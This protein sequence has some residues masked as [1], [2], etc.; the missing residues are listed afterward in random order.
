[1]EQTQSLRMQQ[2]Q[3]QI[4]RLEQASL[5]DM[6]EDEFS[7]LIHNT[8]HSPLFQRIYQQQKIIRHQRFGHTDISTR[9][10]PLNEEMVA[11]NDSLEVESLLVNREHIVSKIH[12]IGPE[13]FKQYFLFPESGLTLEEIATACHLDITQVREINNLIDEF[14]IRSEFYHPSRIIK[15][16]THYTKVASV[17]K[18]DQGF[19]I[20]YYSPSLAR[21]Q[22][23]IDYT[24]FEEQAQ[25]GQ[26]SAVEARE[27][28]QLFKQLQ[29]INSRKDT[30]NQILRS[31]IEKQTLYLES[32]D[33]RAL[34][35]FS[36]KELALRLERAPSS[37]SRAIRGKSID[38]P[39]GQEVA[40]KQFFPRPKRFRKEL[41]RRLLETEPGLST[42]EAIRSMLQERFGVAISRRSVSNLRREL[43]L[44][45]GHRGQHKTKAGDE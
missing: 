28:R 14:S 9:F 39:W 5:L 13:K 22:Y 11:A 17:D 6:T 43:D 3:R 20:G 40:L 45:T 25:S 31:V 33:T 16:T 30:L 42:D 35:P 37:I 32:S 38:T 36:Q 2:A 1:M 29:L 4:L 44:T 12:K 19:I 23:L 41:L 21:G 27:A 34:L 8:E 7:H 24:R 10:Y 18:G 26:L 15:H